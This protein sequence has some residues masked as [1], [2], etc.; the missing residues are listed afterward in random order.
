ME[1]YK[2]KVKIQF[3]NDKG[4]IK[5]KNEEYLISATCITDAE[6]KIHEEFKHESLDWESISITKTKILKVIG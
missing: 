4:Q 6:A 5:T 1:Y 2:G 3:E